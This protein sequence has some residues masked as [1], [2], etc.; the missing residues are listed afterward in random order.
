MDI[1]INQCDKMKF[2]IPLVFISLICIILGCT[3]LNKK[4]GVEDDNIFEELVEHQIE[5]FTMFLL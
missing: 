1:A 3:T 2:M 5:E 4:F